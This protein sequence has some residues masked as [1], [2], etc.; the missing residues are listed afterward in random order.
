[1]R[2]KIVVAGV[3]LMMLFTL[4]GVVAR[5][6]PPPRS[7]AGTIVIVFKDGHR[8]TFNLSEIERV[9]FPAPA[10]AAGDN[11]PANGDA[12]PRGHYVGKWECGDGNGNNFYI[13]LKESGDAMRSIGDEHGRWDYVN[14]EARVTWDDGAQDAIRKIGSHY[15]KFAYHQ[16]KS[17]T[18]QPDNVTVA[19]LTNPRP[20]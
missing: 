11:S 6:A 13:T 9:E 18:D 1:M 14:G 5:P 2:K 4:A 3:S 19:K 10:L 12:P 8:Q 7:A 20:I 15:Q 17:F 16:G